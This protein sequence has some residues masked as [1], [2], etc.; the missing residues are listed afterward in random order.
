[1]NKTELKGYWGEFFS[2]LLLKIKG[3]KILAHRYKTVC[4]EIDIIACKRSTIVFVEVK[5]RK[6]EEKCFTAITKHQLKRIQKASL[7]FL[8]Y[9]PNVQNYFFRYDVILIS[10]WKFPLHIENITM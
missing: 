4:G 2:I 1:M 5:A 7:L 9:H 6:N 10:N 8:K 3:Y